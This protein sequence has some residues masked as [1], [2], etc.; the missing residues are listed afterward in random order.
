MASPL[1]SLPPL[2]HPAHFEPRGLLLYILCLIAL[3][4][5]SLPSY[6][7][8]SLDQPGALGR[9][10]ETDATHLYVTKHIQYKQMFNR[11]SHS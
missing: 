5:L 3:P 9:Q 1:F 8:F 4:I 10:G 6:W 2:T 11:P 7:P